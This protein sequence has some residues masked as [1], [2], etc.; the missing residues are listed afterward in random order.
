[1]TT[2]Y[3]VI[4][5][6][7]S[8]NCKLLN[9]EE[10]YNSIKTLMK[11]PKY[12]YIASCGHEHNVFFNVFK[13]R[14]TGVLCPKCVIIRNKERKKENVSDDKII[15]IRTEFSCIQYF[16]NLLNQNYHVIKAF[17]GCKTDIIL[18][19][20]NIL[21][22]EWIGIQVKSTNKSIKGYGFHIEN[23]YSDFLILCICNENKRMW[24]FPYQN[25]EGLIKITIGNNVS[26]Y[27]IYEIFEKS[28]ENSIKNYYNILKKFTF[29]KLNNPINVY[30]Q[31]ELEY[32]KHREIKIDFL[33]FNYDEME[34]TVY[35]FKI[36]ELKIQEKIGC[37]LKTEQIHFGICK[38]CY[39]KKHVQYNIGDN[40]IYWLNI[41]DK[42]HFYVIP[43]SILVEK[44]FIGNADKDRIHL[45]LPSIK[46]QIKKKHW[47]IEF[48]FDYENIEKEKLLKI[49]KNVKR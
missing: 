29:D 13:N 34:G 40:N 25:V 47:A 19:P 10:E 32:R 9:T 27:N 46:N 42:K 3:D 48:M 1:M 21:K 23:D 26:K 35:D 16:I 39:T 49:I 41:D 28:I 4:N 15:N 22:D 43:E 5:A 33:N 12:N 14:K 8:E 31:R 36:D 37:K 18:K 30:Q 24:L 38:S 45:K 20:K 7:N 44:G 2:Y 17:D 6:F 11:N